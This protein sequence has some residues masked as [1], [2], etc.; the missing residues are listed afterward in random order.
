M[1]D[2]HPSQESDSEAEKLDARQ[3][4][5]KSQNLV[6]KQMVTAIYQGPLPPAS[7]L[8]KYEN[9]LPGAANR[10]LTMVEKQSDHRRAIE[11]RLIDAQIKNSLKGLY[12]AFIILL[13]VLILAGYGFI[14][15]KMPGWSVFMMIITTAGSFISIAN[16]IKE[17]SKEKE[18]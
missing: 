3:E 5:E 16:I 13:G 1:E 6:K 10:I 7:E 4:T 15:G 17:E 14:F 18:K 8:E 9:I 2:T 11:S 12:F